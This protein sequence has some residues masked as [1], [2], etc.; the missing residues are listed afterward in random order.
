MFYGNLILHTMELYNFA[1]SKWK[2]GVPR[3]SHG[4]RDGNLEISCEISNKM[5]THIL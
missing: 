1:M 3:F 5:L 4:S 2:P